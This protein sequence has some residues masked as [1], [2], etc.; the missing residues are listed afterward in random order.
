MHDAA[1]A[2]M[3]RFL[4]VWMCLLPLGLWKDLQWDTPLVMALVSFLLIGIDEIGVQVCC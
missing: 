1:C 4:V 2:P 3:C